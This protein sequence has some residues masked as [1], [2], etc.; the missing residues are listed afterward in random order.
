MSTDSD[1]HGPAPEQWEASTKLHGDEGCRA[2]AG[3]VGVGV[4]GACQCV[5][6]GGSGVDPAASGMGYGADARKNCVILLSPR[7]DQ[8]MRRVD[9]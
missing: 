7:S 6:C 2:H 5:D 3:T 9:R 4:T 1:S 8:R